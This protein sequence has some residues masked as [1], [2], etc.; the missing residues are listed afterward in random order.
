MVQS[1]GIPAKNLGD[2]LYFKIYAKLSDGSY[3]YS[4]LYN[5]SA[6]TYAQER[7]ANSSNEE[8]KALCVALLNYGA[9]AQQ[10]FN[11]KPYKLMNAGLTDAQKALVDDYAPGMVNDLFYVS[12]G[13]IGAFKSTGGFSNL[14]PKVSLGGAF[15]INY[16]FTPI[17]T[18]DGAL[19]FY[20][21]TQDDYNSVSVLTKENASGSMAMSANG[22]TG[23]YWMEYG[24]IG[25]KRIDETV[26]VAGVYES[27]GQTYCTGVIPYSLGA[28]F[29]D[30][31]ENSTAETL[32]NLSKFSAVYGYY[33]KVYFQ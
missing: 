32:V 4:G 12:S 13:K 28:Y 10:Y 21:W 26:F 17:N 20:Y 29:K 30:R 24:G 11:Y 23:E 8:L 22:F 27:N 19:M 25:A 31:I 2:T 18:P 5:Y 7:L 6:K 14:H 9:A 33:A 1:Q 3:I 16:Y 15:S